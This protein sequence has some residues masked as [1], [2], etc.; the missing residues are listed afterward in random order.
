[1]G[2]TSHIRNNTVTEQDA[3]KTSD[4]TRHDMPIDLEQNRFSHESRT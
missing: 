3:E 2:F 4:H 1:M